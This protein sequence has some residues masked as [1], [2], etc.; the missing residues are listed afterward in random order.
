MDLWGKGPEATIG[1]LPHS[2]IKH[3]RI[4]MAA[5]V[6][7]IVQSNGIHFP[8]ATS[9]SGLTYA[10][11][12][13][14][15][16]PAAQWDALPTAAKVQILLVIGLLEFWGESSTALAAAGQKHYWMGG[17]PGFYP[18]FEPFRKNFG[19]PVLDLF[20]PFG[21]SKNAS[22]ERKQKG[23]LAEINNGRLAMIGIMGFMAAASVE[24]SVP[25]LSGLIAHY[26]GEC[27]APFSSTDTSLP[28]VSEMLSFPKLDSPAKLF[29]YN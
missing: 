13:A 1:W 6:G 10:D 15:A 12:A 27:M 3:G 20:D 11:I 4:A 28:L 23:L 26:D 18:S 8:W 24:G 14:N 21:L 22:P 25:A 9:F 5:F 16:A 19:H 2:E 17:K 29:P 7:F